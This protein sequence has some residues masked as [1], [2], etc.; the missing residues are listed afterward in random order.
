M[1]KPNKVR[2]EYEM[3]DWIELIINSFGN[4][5]AFDIADA[6]VNVNYA[7]DIAAANKMLGSK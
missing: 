7:S 4:V 2:G 5:K 1:V 6:Y 3:G